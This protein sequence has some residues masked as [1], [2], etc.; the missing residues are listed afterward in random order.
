GVPPTAAVKGS[1]DGRF[2]TNDGRA[3]FST[4]NSLVPRDG[5]VIADVYEYVDGRPQLISSGTGDVEGTPQ[6]PIGLVGVSSDGIDAFFATFET[7]VGQDENG[8]QFKF[9]DAR[10]NGGF[11][12]EKPAAPCEAADECH[13]TDSSTPA[14][15]QLGTTATL[16]S[17]GNV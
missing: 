15:L 13:G 7:M 1:L 17:G 16:G 10:T 14:P 6:R 3:F 5:N 8:A 9:Y 4:T 11:A 2:M 12:F